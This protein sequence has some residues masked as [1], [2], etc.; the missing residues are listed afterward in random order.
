[1]GSLIQAAKI[2]QQMFKEGERSFL[3]A[4][5]DIEQALPSSIDPVTRWAAASNLLRTV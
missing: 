2:A 3:Q 4:I 5:A 1:M